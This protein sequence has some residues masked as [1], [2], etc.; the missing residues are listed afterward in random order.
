M[1]V[2][3]LVITGF[4]LISHVFA[5]NPLLIP[6]TL[7]G[8]VINLQL[9][10]GSVQFFSGAA[11]QTMGANGNI[12]GPTLFLNKN[13]QV[14]INVSNQLSDSSTIHWHGMHVAPHNDGGP[15]TPILPGQTWSPSFQVLDHAAT[16][17]YHPHLHYKTYDHVQLGIAGFIFIRDA[18]EAALSLPRTYG[19]D[20]VPLAIQTKGID[21][22]NQIRTDHTA[23]DT[24]LVVNGTPNPYHIFPAQWVRLRLLNGSPERVYNLGFSD[25]R[26]FSMIASDNGLLS[27]PVNLT[28]ILLAPG[29]RAEILVNLTGQQGQTFWL[30][31]YG[32]T[33]PNGHYGAA[34]PGMG[35]NQTIPNYNLN[36]LNGTDFNI[37]E[38]RVS[39]PTANPV[40]SIPGTMIQHTPWTAQQANATRT[41]TFTA[42]GNMGGG[43]GGGGFNLEGPYVINGAHFD[44]NV[45]NFTVPFENIEVWE[46]RNQTPIAHPFHVHNVPFYILDING[47]PPPP[48]YRGRKDVVLVPPG[49][50]VVRFITKF[51]DFYNDTLPYMYHCHMLTHEDDGMMG[52]FIVASPCSLLTSSPQNQTVAVGAGS[53]FSVGNLSVP[54]V[55]YQW[56]T[57]LGFG[58]QDL[59]DAGQYSGTQTATLTVSNVSLTNNNQSFRCVVSSPD[60]SQTSEAA[61]LSVFALGAEDYLFNRFAVF[62][63]PAGETLNILAA[64]GLGISSWQIMDLA[65]RQILAGVE[66]IGINVSGLNPGV[67]LFRAKLTDGSVQSVKFIK[68]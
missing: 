6:D 21:A 36:P 22:S 56:Q 60:C 41:L 9:Q 37:L 48:Q 35:A 58:F 39:A 12:L 7:S 33:I 17:W 8:S 50:G 49:N 65:G 32:T 54:G 43:G 53:T 47:N 62:P 51:E 61:V 24:F 38:L 66:S 14:T 45:V 29:E 44:M 1:R 64:D 30:R 16:M 26:S 2:F 25:N 34:Q 13:Q 40:T 57:N 5:Q 31:N 11:T 20:D 4:S 55:T 27:A 3:F 23:L 18:D 63:N 67:Y 46:L 68:E 15:H 59:Q 10:N 52:Q 28:R 42:M 19:I